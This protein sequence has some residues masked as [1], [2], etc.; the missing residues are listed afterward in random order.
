VLD[1]DRTNY[2]VGVHKG[3]ECER[4]KVR[5]TKNVHFLN[6]RYVFYRARGCVLG[7]EINEGNSWQLL[8]RRLDV[9]ILV[10]GRQVGDVQPGEGG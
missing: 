10:T 9:Q 2:E 8:G 6:W 5:N 1:Y 4:R 3:V 7:R